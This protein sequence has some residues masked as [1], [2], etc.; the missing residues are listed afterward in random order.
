MVTISRAERIERLRRVQ[1]GRGDVRPG[2]GV[3]VEPNPE[4]QLR[5]RDS[6]GRVVVAYVRA[7]VPEVLTRAAAQARALRGF[8]DQFVECVPD[9]PQR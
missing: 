2:P 3:K 4:K 8:R 1:A 9:R 5:P 6:M 7:P